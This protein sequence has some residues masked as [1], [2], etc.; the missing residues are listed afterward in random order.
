MSNPNDP[1]PENQ[2]SGSP[3]PGEPE[4]LAVGKLLR[5]HGL[6]G[7]MHLA[8]WTDFP[9]RLQPG[10]QVYVGKAHQPVH[11]KNLRGAE[12]DPLIAFAEFDNREDAAQFRN[13]VV[14]VRTADLPPLPD[15]E[16]YLHQL[17]GL[18]VV[19]DED[20]A[21]LGVLAEILETGANDVFLVRRENGPDL[22][23]PDIDSVILKINL[24]QGEIRVH[25]LPGLL[26]DV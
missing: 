7:E 6:H 19:Q 5:T 3:I 8:L 25:L 24:D 1:T 15:D 13:Q 17:I 26:P 18:R 11:I 22:L 9:E 20:G 12:D 23:L 16:I 4:F 10:V 14:F 21:A 2:D